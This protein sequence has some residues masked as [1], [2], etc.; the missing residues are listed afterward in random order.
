MQVKTYQKVNIAFQPGKIQNARAESPVCGVSRQSYQ[1][2]RPSPTR[3]RLKL[4]RRLDA[5]NNTDPIRS[6]KSSWEEEK[7]AH[8]LTA[9]PRPRSPLHRSSTGTLI[10]RKQCLDIEACMII[11][12][13]FEDDAV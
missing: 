7:I 1:Y 4:L 5:L 9:P 12:N 13:S 2:E 6:D 10:A 11:K 8:I 3:S